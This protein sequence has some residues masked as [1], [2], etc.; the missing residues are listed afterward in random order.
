MSIK[1]NKKSGLP[2]PTKIK[3]I[4]KNESDR[5]NM[6]KKYKILTEENPDCIKI[7][8]TKGNLLYINKGGLKEHGFKSLKEMS[9]KKWDIKESIVEED[10][11]KFKKAIERANKGKSTIIEINHIPIYSNREACSELITPIKNEAGKIVNILGISRDITGIKNIEGELEKSRERLKA[12]IDNIGDGVFVTDNNH[13]IIIFNK[14]ASYIS[15]Y[16]LKQVM[17]KKYNE[18]LKFVDEQANKESLDFI[19][20]VMSSGKVFEIP[21]DIE[22]ITKNKKRIPV[23]GS[24]TLLRDKNNDIRGCVIVFRDITKDKEVNS[25]KTEFVSIASHQLRT[26]LSGIKWFTELLAEESAGELNEQQKNFLNKIYMSNERLISLV[27]DLLDV[28]HIETGGKFKIKKREIN[29]TSLIDQ[30]LDDLSFL[31]NSRDIKIKKSSDLSKRIKIS[32][33]KDKIKQIFFN[34][35]NNALKF[36][37]PG[38]K[39][40]IGAK[41]DNKEMV[42]YVKD[43]GLGIPKNQ[44]KDVFDKFFRGKNIAT[45]SVGTG[46]GLYI[47]KAIVAAHGGRIW[48]TSKLNKGSTFYFSLPIK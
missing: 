34:L 28:S 26:P 15:G 5:H 19:K 10:R 29:T 42:F 46:L 21:D 43:N 27:R 40:E 23:G 2:T 22:L 3:K 39:I 47:T 37:K 48:F 14:Q 38:G 20:K 16:S 33:D 36:T 18:V 9:K 6:E 44:C 8:D 30:V 41:R 4:L 25:L 31:I 7:F 17:G 12:V 24:I 45:Q 32:G 11:I 1:N 13:K 35:I